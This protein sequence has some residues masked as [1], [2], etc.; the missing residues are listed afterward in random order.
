M[1]ISVGNSGGSKTRSLDLK[2]LYKSEVSNKEKSS[3]LGNGEEAETKKRKNRKEVAISSFEDLTERKKIRPSINDIEIDGADSCSAQPSGVGQKINGGSG[4]NAIGINIG[5]DGHGL[6]IPKRPRGSVGRSKFAKNHLLKPS[7]ASGSVEKVAKLKDELK[8]LM[9]NETSGRGEPVDSNS[10]AEQNVKLNGKFGIKARRKQ[11][12]VL[13]HKGSEKQELAAVTSSQC[14]KSD[15]GDLVKPTGSS[16]S[17]DQV[18]KLKYEIKEFPQNKVPGADAHLSCSSLGSE[19]QVDKLK[20]EIKEIPQSIFPGAD[21]PLSSNSTSSD[22]MGKLN[23]NSKGKLRN[24]VKK[25]GIDD[26]DGNQKQKEDLAVAGSSQL[27]MGDGNDM[28]VNNKDSSSKR[29]NSNR[30]KRK[31]LGSGGE[32]VSK[33]VE[34]SI[35]KK[36]GTCD[37]DPDDDLEQNAARMLSSRF[38]PS[39][40][41]FASRNRTSAL[42]SPNGVSLLEKPTANVVSEGSMA[43]SDPAS[44]DTADRVLRPRRQQKGKGTSRK[45]RHFYEIHSDDMDA[46]WFLNR[47]IK[48]FW[49][50]DE[51][52]YYGLVNDYDAEKNLHHIKYDDRDEEWISLE[53]ERFKLLLLPSEVPHKTSHKDAASV[54]TNKE[55]INEDKGSRAF[56]MNDETFMASHMESEPIISWLARSSH[57]VKSSP[58]TSLKKQKLSHFPSEPLLLSD[59]SI[60]VYNNGNMD[61]LERETDKPNCSASFLNISVDSRKN[62]ES[63]PENTNSSEGHLPIVYVRRRYRRFSDAARVLFVNN[64]G[65]VDPSGPTASLSRVFQSSAEGSIFLP[66]L[67]PGELHW[68]LNSAGVLKLNTT[69]LESKKFKICISLWPMLTYILGVDILW[70]IHSVLLL[71][72]GTMVTMWPTVVLE[73]LFVDNIVGLRLF[74]FEGCLKQAVA[75]VFLVMEVFCE[76]EKDESFG[77]QI[78][79]TSIRFKLSFFQKLIKQKVFTYYSFS[80]VRDSNWQYLD[81]EFQPHCLLTKQLS[82]PECTYDNIKLLEAMQPSQLRYAGRTTYFEVLRKKSNCGA[83]LSFNTSRSSYPASG[84]RPSTIYSLKHGNLPPFALSF[85]AA[86]NFFLS[87]HLKLLLERSI[88]SVS[89]QDHDSVRSLNYPRDTF[90]PCADDCSQGED[91]FEIFSENSSKSHEEMSSLDAAGS[92]VVCTSSRLCKDAA[93]IS[94]DGGLRK[95]SQLVPDAK[96]NVNRTSIS[97]KDAE[98]VPVEIGNSDKYEANVKDQAVSGAMCSSY[99]KG[100]SV[101]VPTSDVV[102]RDCRKTP[103]AQQVSDLTWNLSDGIICSP[104]PTGPRSLWHRNKSGS[105]SSSFGDPLHAWP[106]GRADFIGNGFGNGPKKPR[107]QVQYTL[108]SREF[109]FKN[110]GHN[111]IGLPYQRIRKANDKRTS[112]SSKGP[113][114]NLELVACDANILINGGDK[115]WRECGARVFLEVADQNEWKLA[116]KCN[117]ELR[118]SYKVHQDLQPGSTNRYTHAMMWKG[119]KDWALEFPDRSQWF[120]FKEMHE[121]CH[122]RNIRAASIKNI[123]IPGV[124]LIEDSVEDQEEMPF[125]RSPW[126]FRQVRNDV[127]MAM[128]GSHVIYDMDTEDEEWISRSRASCQMQGG[129]DNMISHELFEK[130][131]DMLE[132]VSYAQKRDQ[133]T[134]GE[135]DELIARV[136]PMQV[137]KS[138]YEHWREKRLRK[139]MPLIRQLQPPLWERYQQIC[140]EWDELNPK[141]TT[142]TVTGSLEKASAGD[143][144]P[145]FAFCLKPRGLELLNK[146]SKHRPHKK[147]S[148]SG[149]SHAFLGDHDSHHSSGRRVNAYALGDESPDVSPLL[150]KMYSPRDPGHLSLDAADASAEWNHQLRI[151]RHNS[152]SIRAVVSPKMAVS[153]STLRKATAGNGKRNNGKRLSNAFAD[154]HNQPS[155]QLLLGGSDLDEFRLRDASSAAKHARNMAKLKRERAQKLMLSADLAIHKAVSALMTAEAIKA[156][157]EA[158]SL[159]RSVKS[160]SL[161][162]SPS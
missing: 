85:T 43:V 122:N 151:Q 15:G 7:A 132:K 95:S 56:H 38:D 136:S 146:G 17:K 128:D 124:R 39:C 35:E 78:P 161:P 120:L 51:S 77:Q 84:S 80:K 50:L 70:L 86:P 153:S 24:N 20:Y 16:G 127:E 145:M 79:V 115:G 58:S 156:C 13:G 92:G 143:K 65:C 89:L 19:D 160:T 2:T 26:L 125:I 21:A 71:Q 135:I 9:H 113:R 97:S 34:S 91:Q 116:V 117:G 96:L 131:M 48:I 82:L 31:M 107:T 28:V 72:Y 103:G 41:G 137:A 54:H 100:I 52:W 42:L 133:F 130:V 27:V 149:H 11:K 37:L 157:T 44:A 155:R 18:A 46:H 142:G 36:V 49:P 40:T 55:G 106:E 114:R 150:T 25:K 23:E 62:E 139:G 140:R 33:K 57:R 112:D 129:E 147:I 75:F 158:A 121:E 3:W 68:S 88:T 141:L 45:R 5:G 159:G 99:L 60:D 108:P 94:I 154:W 109:N 102:Y 29:N 104:N 162:P 14:A 81:S 87:L 105:I 61:L 53:N 67:G 69:F 47:R 90:H 148:L 138:I 6:L 74:I 30:R 10:S 63:V 73:V 134:S 4:F 98:T 22:Q 123:P 76:P 1:E 126:Y 8:K 12:G 93:V 152:K 64:N 110:K 111:Q 119:G 83:V 32:T 144:P 101:E 66:C 59:N 118:Y